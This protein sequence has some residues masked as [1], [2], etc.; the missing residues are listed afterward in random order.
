MS[1][2]VCR[3]EQVVHPY[4]V[5]GLGVNIHSSQEFCYAIYHHP[6]LFLDKF[7][8]QS[9]IDF[10]R[11][12]LGMG[13]LAARMEQRIKTKEKPEE[14]MLMPFRPASTRSPTATTRMWGRPPLPSRTARA[15]TTL[16]MAA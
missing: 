16:S 3:P 9:V 13:F 1:V 14:L 15:A 7:A 4:Y 5:E 12:E 2:I 8:D 6:M 11:D 10:I